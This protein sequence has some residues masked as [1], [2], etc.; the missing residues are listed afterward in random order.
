MVIASF[1]YEYDAPVAE[2]RATALTLDRTLLAD[3]LGEPAFRELLDAGAIDSVEADLQHLS[4]ER[5]VRSSDAM[6]D[7]LR[8]VGPLSL[9]EAAMRTHEPA[10]AQEW[11]D[12]LT[13]SGRTVL[14]KV[15][16]DE[17]Y[18]AVEDLA[19]LRDAIG[20]QPPQR[21]APDLLEPVADPLDST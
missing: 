21:I 11:L 6:S 17:R 8:D 15:N 9:E 16:D 20:V 5:M 19:R 10:K 3:L 1:M 18:I 13:Q 2:R 7:M 4:T 14:L 12:E